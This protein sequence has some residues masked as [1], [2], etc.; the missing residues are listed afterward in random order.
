VGDFIGE[1]QCGPTHHLGC[2]CHEARRDA[3]LGAVQA[4]AALRGA[5]QAAIAANA[6]ELATD[7]DAIEILREALRDD[8]ELSGDG[9][10]TVDVVFDGPP[11]PRGGRFVEVEINGRSVSLGEWIE[12]P[13]GYW[14]LRL[15]AIGWKVNAEEEKADG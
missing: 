5:V 11:G 10:T 4:E 3:E 1:T 6:G 13:D 8:D 15:P 2:A 12:R 9:S 14:A 7:A